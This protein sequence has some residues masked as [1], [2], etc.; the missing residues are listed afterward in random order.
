LSDGVVSSSI[1][2]EN[3]RTLWLHAR[4]YLAHSRGGRT[5]KRAV[6]RHRKKLGAVPRQRVERART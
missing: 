3:K 5:S 4:V 6:E 1:I 2:P